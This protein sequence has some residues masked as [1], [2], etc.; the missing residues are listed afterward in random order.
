MGAGELHLPAESRFTQRGY[1]HELA[2][3]VGQMRNP[4]RAKPGVEVLLSFNKEDCHL[5]EALRATL[6]MLEPNLDLM[7]VIL[8]PACYGAVQFDDAI[9]K[10]VMEADR[11][12]LLV[13]PRGVGK[14]QAIECNFA[15]KRRREE[16]EFSVIP[17]LAA[18]GKRPPIEIM[19]D[20]NWI[21][22]PIVTDRRAV[23]W[24]LEALRDT[25]SHSSW[26]FYSDDRI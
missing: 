15:L 16:R 21:E 14:W 4:Q 18:N 17:V 22:V 10:G 25:R 13:G 12:L 24:I 19:R 7:E 20:L 23:R 26:G 5:A 8:S 6:F 9:A 11:F 1:L 2:F 3:R